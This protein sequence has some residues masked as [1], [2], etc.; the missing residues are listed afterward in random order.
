MKV[1]NLA[2]SSDGNSTYI[3]SEECKILLDMG[4]SCTETS[5]RLA[6]IGVSPEEIDAV[7]VSHE[8]GDHMKGVDVFCSK[9]NKPVFAHRSVWWGLNSKL[10]RVKMENR[11]MFD[12]ES[13]EIK[14]MTIYPFM[15]PHDVPCFGFSFVK[16][17][18]KISILTDL[19][20]TT[21]RIFNSIRGSQI[22]YLE[23][24]YDKRMLSRNE[25][26]PLILKKR[27]AGPNGH[28]SNEDAGELIAH[29]VVTGTKQVI[30]SHLSRDNNS[31]DMAYDMVCRV[32]SKYG[33]IE[34][35]HV[36]ID[37]ATQSPGVLFKLN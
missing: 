25:K 33:L 3:E 35:Q 30:L 20:H 37:V 36:M 19:G 32:L 12:G 2:S 7:I 22:V 31:P 6:M 18:N 23:S 11:K 14:D 17:R 4:L 1:I 24:N 29:L 27:I 34:G 16:K 13:F 28:L 5:K 21:D 10:S 8:H 26:Y 9:F 15:L